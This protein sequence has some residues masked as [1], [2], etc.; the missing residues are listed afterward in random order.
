VAGHGLAWSLVA[1][2]LALLVWRRRP[3]GAAEP[4]WSALVWT[5]LAGVGA[6]MGLALAS[7]GAGA[8][9]T[10]CAI[11]YLLVLGFAALVLV[12]ATHA[13][14]ARLVPG[15]VLAAGA[16]A[17]ALVL[18]LVPGRATP[19]A[20]ARFGD[21]VLETHAAPTPASEDDLDAMVERLPP[22]QRQL[23]S[24]ALAT[25]EASPVLELEPRELLGPV[26]A[27]VRVT[28]F[29]DAGCPHCAHFHEGLEKMMVQLPAGRVALEARQFP[30][31][32][33]CNPF[34][35]VSAGPARCT[36]AR[37]RIC[38][39]GDPRAF[40][41]ESQLFARQAELSEAL[42][43]ELATPILGRERLEAC[44]ASEKTAARL[45][46]D[47]ELAME[48][49]IQGTPFVLV[50]GR[51]TIPD[52][53]FVY[54]M[55]LTEGDASHPAFRKLPPPRLAAAEDGDVL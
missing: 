7:L 20:G 55:A 2:V 31:D 27:P 53:A 11:T 36:A 3:R 28:L 6:V 5:A 26:D 21:A 47:I 38:L 37:A 17:L 39:E 46:R 14:P 24:D 34:V 19:G 49:G 50:N 22:D 45:R 32:G 9:C 4:V 16:A 18:L 8:L 29:T 41:F 13:R 42:V 12:E 10:S 33:A 54:A 40:A 25:W 48:G 52:L 44:M 15:A 23:L 51:A 1:L 30:L 43:Y 35:P